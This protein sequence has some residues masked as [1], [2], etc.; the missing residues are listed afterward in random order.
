MKKMRKVR[1]MGRSI[2]S[3]LL[4]AVMVC[5]LPEIPGYA[6]EYRGA[7]TLISTN[8][9]SIEAIIPEEAPGA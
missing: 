1:R 6:Q 4:N 3:D 8:S 9:G 7:E 2:V 5:L